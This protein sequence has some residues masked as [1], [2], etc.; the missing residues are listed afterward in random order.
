MYFSSLLAAGSTCSANLR[1]SRSGP[2]PHTGRG[3]STKTWLVSVMAAASLTHAQL[4]L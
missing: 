2:A 4:E 3:V 1:A